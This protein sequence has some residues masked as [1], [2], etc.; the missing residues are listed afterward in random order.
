MK[1]ERNR[2]VRKQSDDLIRSD[3]ILEARCSE[4]VGASGI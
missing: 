2:A 1:A 4:K 3:I